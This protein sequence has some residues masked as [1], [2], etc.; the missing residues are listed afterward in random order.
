M[1]IKENQAVNSLLNSYPD[2]A[3]QKLLY[4]RQLIIETAS[5]IEE[6]NI[7]EE[8][9]KWGEP[10]YLTKNGSTIRIDWKK[11]D[12]CHYAMHFHCK[13]NLV[14]TFRELYK[15]KLKFEGN[16]AIIFGINDNVP[17][18]EL[19]HCIEL[20]LTYHT[21]KKNQCWAYKK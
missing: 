9:L 7:I 19:K 20:S 21:R 11:K 3:K 5:E 12:P 4:L 15:N 1:Q 6:I 2:N 8:T 14:D 10:A 16:R 13:T 18:T 17:V